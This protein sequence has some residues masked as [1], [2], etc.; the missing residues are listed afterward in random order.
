MFDG[1][2]IS[3]DIKQQPERFFNALVVAVYD[4]DPQWREVELD[5]SNGEK[6]D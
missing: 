1:Q 6:Y 5:Y 4:D 3:G 2:H